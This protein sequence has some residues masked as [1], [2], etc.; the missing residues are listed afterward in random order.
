[1]KVRCQHFGNCPLQLDDGRAHEVE[2]IEGIGCPLHA[3]G[4]QCQVEA[5]RGG[6][7]GAAL[8]RRARIAALAVVGAGLV[9]GIGWGGYALTAGAFSG[10][11]VKDV[12][13]LMALDPKV[14]ELESSGIDCF[15]A[16]R[17]DGDVGKLVAG[18]TALRMAADKG[19]VA[20]AFQL[21][22]MLDPLAR[23]AL[24]EDAA[25]VGL[26]PAP[27]PAEALR[28]Y[29]KAGAH[30]GA[31]EAAAAL[32]AKFPEL[33]ADATG[34]DGAPLAMPGHSGLYQR[35]LT[36]PGAL[37]ATAPGGTGGAPLPT[38]DI[39][40]VFGARPGW[41][42]VGHTLEN[43]AEGW[44]REEAVQPWNVMLVMQY[45]PQGGRLPVLF[46]Q[47]ETALKGLLIG[48]DPAGEADAI[49]RSAAT[50]TPD[51]RLL[52]VEERA[53]DWQTMPYVMP[54]LKASPVTANDGRTVYLANI[55][56]VAGQGAR[57]PAAAG[58]PGYCAGSALASIVHEIVFVIDT[59]ASMGPYIDGVRRIAATW[60]DEI[61]RRG[62]KDKFRFGVVAYR[63]NMDA[64][65]QRSGLEYVTR[66]ALPLSPQ[67]D[68]DR[69]VAAMD[70][71][72]PATVS[73]HSFDEDAVAG[74][75][76]GLGFDWRQGCGLRMLFLVTDA[77]ALRSD[78]PHARHQGIGL[79]TIAARAAGD[80]ISVL[81]VHIRTAEAR[82]ARNIDGAAQQYR[83]E[84][85]TDGGTSSYR[86]IEGGSSA[87]FDGYLRD[88]GT[89][90]DAI[91][92]ERRNQTVARPAIAAADTAVSVKDM[93]LGKL[94]SVQQRFLGAAA[95]VSAPT[96]QSS[97]TSDRD[98]ANLDH[99]A[100]EVSVYLTR[101]QLNQLAE[102]TR[103]LV[104][105]ATLA[106]TGSAEFFD[107]LRTLSAATAQDPQR[108]TGERAALGALM[109]SFLT[110]L[111]YRS[112]ALA[113]TAADWRA[114]GP[115]KQAAFVR[116]LREKLSYYAILDGDQSRWRAIGS[117]DPAELVA[118]VPLRELP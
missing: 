118:L 111:P 71:L 89:L 85:R 58:T 20:A 41:R 99:A 57:S 46:F 110:L 82:A 63:N 87:A 74:L 52:G 68:A 91:A 59:T 113:L 45:A 31:P 33:R 50:A 98:L 96:F 42:Q 112:D 27:D 43:G 17:R 24:E 84:L 62:L 15:D 18:T 105:N 55:A 86:L 23:P 108:F 60:R 10:C 103:S 72:K 7:G 81:P 93:V 11:E 19:S 75:H 47:D 106:R 64:E 102:K 38:F 97:W 48:G 5:V 109:P 16:G 14:G 25:R 101:R 83:T 117:S 6:G 35:V 12:E 13:Q 67:A 34:R 26:L 73:T 40:Y 30:A 9:G 65:P 32:R 29:L 78:D 39:L 94:F 92:A 95:Q 4:N 2:S 54:V 53:V 3:D 21:G 36:K 61:A 107:L 79:S 116:R 88:V 22:R 37:L 49:A 100:L 69:F 66:V 115:S 8:T 80:G 56:S 77:G 51:P 1:M 44:V 28:F 90:I 70:T 76:E 104:A 114:M